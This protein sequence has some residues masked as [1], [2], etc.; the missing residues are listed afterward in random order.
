M[1]DI[2]SRSLELVI[3]AHIDGK[4]RGRGIPEVLREATDRLS[5]AGIRYVLA[6]KLAYGFYAPAQ[7]TLDIELVAMK[8]AKAEIQTVFSQMGCIAVEDV[9]HRMTY[10][11]PASEVKIHVLMGEVDPEKSAVDDA[12]AAALFNLRLPL[13]KPEYLLWIYCGSDRVDRTVDAIALVKSGTVDLA[14]LKRR[15]GGAGDTAAEGQLGV[16]MVLAEKETSSSYTA[17]IGRR[18]QMR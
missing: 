9:D 7:F 1:P 3:S 13:I 8:S 15:L 14:L 16:A 18:L 10:D 6:G 17:T 11:A 5:R 12:C 2:L 4:L